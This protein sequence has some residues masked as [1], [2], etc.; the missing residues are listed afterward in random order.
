MGMRLENALR[1]I[2]APVQNDNAGSKLEESARTCTTSMRRVLVGNGNVSV[3]VILTM[4]N[5]HMKCMFIVVLEP[6]G[7]NRLSI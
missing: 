1:A 4:N 3:I 6:I 2:N 7:P 5:N